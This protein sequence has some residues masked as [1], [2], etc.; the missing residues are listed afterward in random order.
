MES[1]DD[2][3]KYLLIASIVKMARAK[4]IMMIATNVSIVRAFVMMYVTGNS[5]GFI[6]FACPIAS[7][8]YHVSLFS[9]S[10]ILGVQNF[11]IELST[12]VECS[13]IKSNYMGYSFDLT[14]TCIEKSFLICICIWQ[15]IVDKNYNY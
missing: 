1:L 5:G 9:I 13:P 7:N 8:Q 4:L 6:T 12:G 15:I 11:L 3:V 10:I 14:C 2:D